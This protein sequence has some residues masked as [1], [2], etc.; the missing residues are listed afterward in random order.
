MTEPTAQARAAAVLRLALELMRGLSAGLLN[1]QRFAA[2]ADD[3]LLVAAVYIGQ[4][5]GKP[6]PAAKLAQYAGLARPTAVRRLGEME[7][8][9]VVCALPGKRYVLAGG[10][11]ERAEAVQAIAAAAAQLDRWSR[12]PKG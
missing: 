12:A 1:E 7:A 6:M 10:F 11:M 2:R 8:A 3:L 4:A 9:G 5:D